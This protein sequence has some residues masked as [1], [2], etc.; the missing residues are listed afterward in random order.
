MADWAAQAAQQTLEQKSI[1]NQNLERSNRIA[2]IK[3]EAGSRFFAQLADWLN[4]EVTDYNGK[5][6]K[7]ADPTDQ[8]TVT[9][10]P[11]I[12]PISASRTPDDVIV[13][14]RQD[15]K[16]TALTIRYSS[17][18]G[19]LS[20]ECGDYAGQFTLCVGDNDQAFFADDL[21]TPKTLEEIGTEMLT[22]FMKARF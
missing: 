19:T 5:L 4:K 6:A 12:K 2:K 13:V 20:Y 15:G 22:K 3:T 18:L 21:H 11:G 17:V 9:V 7:G 14:G 8:L 16:K 10:T 1:F